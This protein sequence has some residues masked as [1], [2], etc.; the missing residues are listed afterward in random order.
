M[1]KKW[2]APRTEVQKFEANE[3]VAACWGVACDT[4]AAER[5]EWSQFHT[6]RAHDDDVCGSFSNQIIYDDD[7]DGEADRMVELHYGE[8]GA[9]LY[10]DGT[11]STVLN[12]RDVKPGQTLYWITKGPLGVIDYHHQG[13]VQE[14]FP[15][16]P[17]RS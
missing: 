12:I 9:T 7:N 17:N 2:V 5:W 1:K 6:I 14:T 15:G 4:A 13:I 11:Y 10:T 16:H 8:N 3:C